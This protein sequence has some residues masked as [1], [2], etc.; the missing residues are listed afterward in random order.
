MKQKTMLI[1]DDEV[2]L[3]RSIVAYFEDLNFR[4]L[5]AENGEDGLKIFE[6]EGVDIILTDLRMPKVSG[7]EVVQKVADT[8]DT[9]PIIVVSGTGIISDAIETVRKGAWDYV[10]KPV[11]DLAVLEHVVNKALEKADLIKENEEYRENLEKLVLEKTEQLRESELE[12][13]QHQKLEAVGQLASG[14]AHDF[15]NQLA[16]IIGFSELLK[17]DIKNKEQLEYVNGILLASERASDL[18]QKLLTFARKGEH[19]VA[20]FAPDEIILETISMLSRTVNKNIEITSDL[21]CEGQLI[22]G[23]VSQIANA[24]LNLGVNARDAMPDGGKLTFRSSISKDEL[25]I[26]IKDSGTGIPEEIRTKIFEPFFTTKGKNKGT[27]MGLAAVYGTMKQHGGDIELNSS[28]NGTEF[29]L[30]F[31]VKDSS[32]L[33][34]KKSETEKSLSEQSVITVQKTNH[35]NDGKIVI[36]IADDEDIVRHMAEI[37]LEKSGYKVIAFD[38]GSTL[39]EYYKSHADE[40]DFILLDNLMPT[41]GG[42]ETFNA[43]KKFDP[44]VKGAIMSGYHSEEEEERYKSMGLKGLIKK[45]FTNQI[46]NDSIKKFISI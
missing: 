28:K 42:A 4:T 44:E 1:I 12:M 26:S 34:T 29:F 25:T 45:P 38:D 14:V 18:T 17:L 35:N 20:P 33:A 9:I 32:E 10:T 39:L 11:M 41:L 8:S 21:N 36:A 40:I 5:E 31:P 46:L 23:D 19:N 43:I 3:R 22:E 13:Q 6:E 15:N 2:G 16:G 27:G 7:M 30:H 37:L 24:L